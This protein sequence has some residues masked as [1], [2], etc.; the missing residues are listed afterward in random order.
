LDEFVAHGVRFHPHLP[1]N[2]EPG[3]LMAHSDARNRRRSPREATTRVALVLSAIALLVAGLAVWQYW[4]AT[5]ATKLATVREWAA[6]ARTEAGTPHSLLLG[7]NSISL[8]EQIGASG[9]TESIQLL[10][11]LL[12]S[13]GGIPLHHSH[14]VAAAAFSPNDRW[15]ASASAGDVLLWN[16]Q[17]PRDLLP[18]RARPHM[19]RE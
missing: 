17:A 6:Q 1:A 7:M 5:K 16:T 3:S 8:A 14:P 4:E 9:P 18:R 19:A 10:N 12:G 11:D 15:L 13:T 2:L